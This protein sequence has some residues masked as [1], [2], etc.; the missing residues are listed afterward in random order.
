MDVLLGARSE[1]SLLARLRA[2]AL[3]DY[4]PLA[5]VAVAYLAIRRAVL[6]SVLI[7]GEAIA[8]LDNP[9]VPVTTTALGERL[10]AKT[11]QALMTAIAVVTEYA[12]LLVWPVRL[13]P[14]YSFNQTPLVT[15][16]LD[17]R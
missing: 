5:A 15:S 7:A 17:V 1:Q 8:P 9:L 10:G 4:L 11:G 6:G 13:S 2:R 12:R 14:D 16:V 3:S